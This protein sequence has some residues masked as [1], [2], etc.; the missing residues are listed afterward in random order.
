MLKR[1][2]PKRKIFQPPVKLTRSKPEKDIVL[3]FQENT[4]KI[5]DHCLNNS[6]LTS[7]IKNLIESKCQSHLEIDKMTSEKYDHENFVKNQ[8]DQLTAVHSEAIHQLREASD[9]DC[10]A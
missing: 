4:I 9:Q 3:F 2:L 10:A 6:A 7:D 5:D 1:F 8:I